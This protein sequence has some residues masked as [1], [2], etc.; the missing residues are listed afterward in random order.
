MKW[1]FKKRVNTLEKKISNE[2]DIY[3]DFI[4]NGHYLSDEETF[5]N[6][7]MLSPFCGLIGIPS[8]NYEEYS[9]L[10]ALHRN[11]IL[12]VYEF[13]G[14]M[15][16]S[17]TLSN[18]GRTI[19]HGYKLNSDVIYNN[20]YPKKNKEIIN[21]NDYDLDSLKSLSTFSN[22]GHINYSEILDEKTDAIMRIYNINL[23]TH[24]PYCCICQG[25]KIFK[26]DSFCD[27]DA[28]YQHYRQYVG[29]MYIFR[30]VGLAS[31]LVNIC[32]DSYDTIVSTTIGKFLYI[33][34]HRFSNG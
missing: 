28:L 7:F 1:I 26:R 17:N 13:M 4:V 22:Y 29:K 9:G 12:Y 15:D 19:I 8:R 24:Y 18:D 3:K 21:I 32:K 34:G 30:L 6:Y 25:D 11:K 14:I 2:L 5:Y 33:M 23:N 16:K 10:E 20:E 27:L 31:P